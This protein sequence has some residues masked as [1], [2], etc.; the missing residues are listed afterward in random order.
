MAD[1]TGKPE[2]LIISRDFKQPVGY[3]Y[4]YDVKIFLTENDYFF[5]QRGNAMIVGYTSE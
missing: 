3:S 1:D 4:T 2:L 5:P